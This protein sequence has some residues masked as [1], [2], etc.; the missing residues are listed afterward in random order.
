MKQVIKWW[1]GNLGNPNNNF[2]FFE[3]PGKQGS[4]NFVLPFLSFTKKI[5][6][7]YK[8]TRK[9]GIYRKK[10]KFHKKVNFCPPFWTQSIFNIQ[11]IGWVDKYLEKNTSYRGI[12]TNFEKLKNDKNISIKV[13]VLIMKRYKII[14]IPR[15][16]ARYFY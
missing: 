10:K 1:I 5:E 7:E 13:F 9:K 6:K 16:E 11:K 3:N 4:C 8:S 2:F 12:C 15:C 14:N